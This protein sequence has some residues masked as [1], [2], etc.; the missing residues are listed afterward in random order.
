MAKIDQS[1]LVFTGYYSPWWPGNIYNEMTP[2]G[3]GDTASF[4]RTEV[5]ILQAR[6]RT[7]SLAKLAI[8]C[9]MF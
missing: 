8:F 4:E 2:Q 5:D 7:A 9:K 6:N 1:M 3:A